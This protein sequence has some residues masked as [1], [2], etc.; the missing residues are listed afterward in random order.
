MSAD[1]HEFMHAPGFPAG[2]RTGVD[3]RL[4][5]ESPAVPRGMRAAVVAAEGRF[6]AA[7]GNLYCPRA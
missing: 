5:H 7:E 2:R 6:L 4:T 3:Q 1:A